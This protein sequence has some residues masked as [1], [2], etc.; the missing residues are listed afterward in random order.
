MSGNFTSKSL[1]SGYLNNVLN[2]MYQVPSS[3][4]GYLKSIYVTSNSALSQ[5]ITLYKGI[6]GN[7]FPWA[8][9]TLNSGEWADVLEGE[10]LLLTAN[11][12]IQGTTNLV[13][14]SAASYTFHGVEEK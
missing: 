4:V 7:I 6:N 3:N 11:D 13:A 5:Q 12:S 8:T 14:V 2:V 10:P 9:F 1:S